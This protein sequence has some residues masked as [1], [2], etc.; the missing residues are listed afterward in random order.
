MNTFDSIPSRPNAAAERPKRSGASLP[1]L[2]SAMVTT[3]LCAPTLKADIDLGSPFVLTDGFTQLLDVEDGLHTSGGASIGNQPHQTALA[4]N[5]GFLTVGE[6][7][8]WNN[9]GLFY[10]GSHFGTQDAVGTV[11][12]LPGSVFNNVSPGFDFPN[13]PADVRIGQGGT[14]SVTLH[15][16]AVWN[17]T[18][19]PNQ[20]NFTVG[21]G[22]TLLIEGQLLS[23]SSSVINGGSATVNGPAAEWQ[24]GGFGL[25]VEGFGVPGTLAVTG[26]ARVYDVPFAQIGF[27]DNNSGQLTVGGNIDEENPTQSIFSASIMEIGV[28][29]SAQGEV[30]VEEGGRVDIGSLLRLGRGGGTGTLTVNEGGEVLVGGFFDGGFFG[31]G[32]ELWDNGTIDLS[33]GGRVVIGTN[34]EPLLDPV[35][36]NPNE[37]ENIDPGTLLV[38]SGGG[39]LSGTGT[40]IGS[41]VVD[42]GTVSPGHSPGTLTING[43][44]FL[45]SGELELEI[46]T[47]LFDQIVVGGDIFFGDNYLINLIFDSGPAD[48]NIDL[49]SLFDVTGEVLFGNAF[50]LADNLIIGGIDEGTI[51]QISLFD[52]QFT[53][54]ASAVPVPAAVWLLGSG[55]LGLLG[56]A[57][58]RR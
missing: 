2:A 33:G 23:D 27:S 26:G 58:R 28:H 36:G 57:R 16:G 54:G 24:V 14:G 44:L 13:L 25:D 34:T 30:I 38:G 35:G 29:G 9:T 32:I 21:S 51:L 47:S 52:Q 22:G 55:L 49:T 8:V 7:V 17:N 6:D 42:G 40:I 50:S 3:L 43:D 41:V 31:Q 15:A 11:E 48:T 56:V 1:V 37:F 53:Y 19:Q 20:V 4:P 5:S 45:L 12:F 18:G 39:F 10:V 46:G